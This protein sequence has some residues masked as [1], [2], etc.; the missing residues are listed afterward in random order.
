MHLSGRGGRSAHRVS[1]ACQTDASAQYVHL[2]ELAICSRAQAP[3]TAAAAVFNNQT[4]PSKDG[5]KP[6]GTL[7]LMIK[8]FHNMNDTVRGPGVTINGVPWKIMVMPRQH[9]MQKKGTQKCLGFFL[10]CCPEAYSE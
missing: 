9:V 2:A 1:V 5:C 10:Q 8:N 6:E 7:K 4:S 3:L